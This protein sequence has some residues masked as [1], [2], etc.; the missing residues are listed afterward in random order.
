MKKPE[1]IEIIKN[2][3][4]NEECFYFSNID[5]C[6]VKCSDCLLK[7]R[8]DGCADSYFGFDG[9]CDCIVIF[10]DKICLIECKNGKFGSS[11]AKKSVKQI[12]KCYKFVKNNSN[13]R[14]IEAVV[15]FGEGIEYTSMSRVKAE[16]KWLYLSVK[17]YKCGQ[18]LK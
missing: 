8:F 15:Y 12:E 1:L 6:R 9:G 7:V 10:K 3:V 14:H 4:Q 18:K 13:N 2:T 17:F 16:L 11:D 5:G